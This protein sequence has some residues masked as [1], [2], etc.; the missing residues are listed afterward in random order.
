MK[1]GFFKPPF[2]EVHMGVLFAVIIL[3][4]LGFAGWAFYMN[5]LNETFSVP[6]LF[7]INTKPIMPAGMTTSFFMKKNKEY[8]ERKY[9][10]IGEYTLEGFA[11]P[12][13]HQA[14]F[15]AEKNVYIVISQYIP[16]KLQ[17]FMGLTDIPFVSVYSVFNN[18]SD[19]ETTTRAGS[20]KEV[21]SNFRRVFNIGDLPIE[22]FI[23]KHHEQLDK[24]EVSGVVE[25]KLSKEDF[26]KNIE[27]GLKID[28][29]HK[30]TNGNVVKMDVEEILK[31]LTLKLVPK[32]EEPKK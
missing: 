22:L 8:T 32:N 7:K 30:T 28:I 25:A 20:E 26:F 21:K 6:E 11:F 4:G 1:G 3:G 24:V 14:F 27:R 12:N 29:A 18:G 16:N 31:R 2:C 19:M 15:D 23:S 17:K 13:Y 5:K 10:K 9:E